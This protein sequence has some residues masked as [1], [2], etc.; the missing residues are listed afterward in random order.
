MRP[1]A[2]SSIRGAPPP[3]DEGTFSWFL[4]HLAL[5]LLAFCFKTK[6]ETK[7]KIQ[8]KTNKQKGGGGGGGEV[9][10]VIPIIGS[11]LIESFLHHSFLSLP[12][13]I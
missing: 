2:S 12:S 11:N 6:N 7:K 3:L 1:R 8:N 9:Y 13:T 4:K 10:I 5:A